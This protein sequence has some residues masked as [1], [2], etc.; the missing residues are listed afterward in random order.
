MI[1]EGFTR[2]WCF[3]LDCVFPQ[4]CLGCEQVDVF[5]CNDCKVKITSPGYFEEPG[6]HLTALYSLTEY[7]SDSVSGKLI[8]SLKYNFSSEASGEIAN[9]TL[10]SEEVLHKI[11]TDIVIPIPLHPRRYAERGFNQAEIIARPVAIYLKKPLAKTVLSRVKAT[12]QQ[13]LL[14]KNEREKNVADAFVVT[15]PNI[16]NGKICLLVDDV[17]TTG[18]TMEAAAKTLLNSGAIK[19]VGFTLARTG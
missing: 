11:T 19:V 6:K 14:G 3:I 10:R 7:K 9:W 15:K 5:L 2:L 8:E 17:Y 4:S 12:K 18:S 13:A 1:G 16:V